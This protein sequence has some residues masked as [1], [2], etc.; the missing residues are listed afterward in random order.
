MAKKSNAEVRNHLSEREWLRN[1]GKGNIIE[2]V[3]SLVRETKKEEEADKN[4]SGR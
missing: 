4:N 3:Q 1:L 2:G